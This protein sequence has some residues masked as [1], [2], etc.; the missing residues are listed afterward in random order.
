[1]TCREYSS[2]KQG[3]NY[4]WGALL[5]LSM[6]VLAPGTASAIT[7]RIAAGNSYSVGLKSDGTVWAWGYNGSGQLGD[8]TATS[9]AIPGKVAALADITTIAAG[10]SHVLALRGDGTVW[11]W[12]ANAVGQMGN[13][14]TADSSSPVQ[15]TGVGNVTAVAAGYGHSAV[16]KGD[17]TVWTWGDN[18]SG[19]LGNGSLI[20]RSRPV[21]VTGL[22]DVRGVAAGEWH[23]VVIKNDGTV[24]AWGDNSSGQLGNGTTIRQSTP[25]QVPGVSGIIAVAVGARHTIALKND[26]S[27]WAWGD[28]SSGQLG[29]GTALNRS[30]PVSIAGVPAG[31]MVSAN[32]NNSL[33]LGGNGTVWAWGDNSYGQ[34]GEGTPFSTPLPTQVNGVSGVTAVAAGTVHTVILKSDNTVWSWGYGKY[35]QLGY[36]P[37][38]VQVPGLNVITTVTGNDHILALPGDGTVWGW[39]DNN[40]GQLGDGTYNHRTTPAKVS[41][42][43]HVTKVATGG[44]HSA[45]IKDDGSLWT[46]G[47]NSFG[48]LGDGSTIGRAAPFQVSALSGAVA[49]AGGRGHTVAVK[50]D[51]TVW[52]W[53]A[54]ASGQLGDGTTFGRTLPV[55]VNGLSSVTAV[56]AG[57]SHTVALKRDGTVWSWGLNS[58]GQLGD[59]TTVNRPSPVQVLG[60]TGVIAVSA[61][62]SHTVV[63]K[64]DGTVWAWGA[65]V[66]GQL[67]DGSTVQRSAPVQVSGIVSPA[68]VVAGHNYTI[69]TMSDGS[70]LTWGANDL[71]QL[72]DGTVSSRS[73]PVL[74][75][76]PNRIMSVAGGGYAVRIDGSVWGWGYGAYRQLGLSQ[77][78]SRISLNAQTPTVTDFTLP[79]YSNLLSVPITSF[80]ALGDGVVTSYCV[81]SSN[82]ITDCIWNSVTPA[83]IM[84]P[85]DGNYTF[86]AWAR[87]AGGV[88]SLPVSALVTVDSTPPTVTS[89]TAPIRSNTLIIPSIEIIAT[90]LYKVTDYC[91]T[92]IPSSAGCLWSRSTPTTFTVPVQGS[93]TFYAWA[94]DLVGNVSLPAS[95][96]VVVDLNLP[97]L[98]TDVIP[99][100]ITL[101]GVLPMTDNFIV[102]IAPF[103]AT[104]ND[105]VNGYQVTLSSTAPAATDPNWTAAPPATVILPATTLSGTVQLYAW[106]RDW[107]GNI[108]TPGTAAMPVCTIDA[109]AGAGGSITGA[110]VSVISCGTNRL[111]HLEPKPGYRIASIS[112]DGSAVPVESD[113]LFS[114]VTTP[115]HTIVAT[116]ELDPFANWHKVAAGGNHTLAVRADGTL[117]AWGYNSKNQLGLSVGSSAFL[118]NP[119][120]VGISSLWEDVA[121][122]PTFSSGTHA[123]GSLWGWGDNSFGQLGNGTT[124]TLT[125]PTRINAGPWSAIDSGSLYGAGIGVNGT[126]MMWGMRPGTITPGTIAQ[127]G[128]DGNWLKLA[129][130]GGHTLAIK[131]DGTLWSWGD[132]VG[133]QLGVGT[134]TSL[135]LPTR[136]GAGASWVQI[137]AGK[138]HSVA[139]EKNGN[140]W[141]WGNNDSGQLGTDQLSSS[142]VPY[143]VGSGQIWTAIAAGDN[144][145]LA[146]RADGTLWAFGANL[147]GELGDGTGFTK[148]YFTQVGS[149]ADWKCISA[150]GSTSF[151][152][153]NDNS[154]WAWGANYVTP[155]LGGQLGDGTVIDKLSPVLVGTNT[156]S[157][158]I[159]AVAGFGGNISPS[160]PVTIGVGTSATFN[161]ASLVG[162][163]IAEV[164]VD[165]VSSLYPEYLQALT[166]SVRF[167][168]VVGPHR[169]EA[170]FAA[171][172]SPSTIT[173]LA[174][175]GGSISPSGTIVVQNGASQ[176]FVMGAKPGYNIVDLLVDDVSQGALTGYTFAGVVG[177]HTIR[178]V[179]GQVP[180]LP[181]GSVILNNGAP[182]TTS[183]GVVAAMTI[184]QA[185]WMRF[186]WDNTTWE[187]WLPYTTTRNV[188]LPAGDGVKTLYVQFRNESGNTSLSSSASILL[189]TTI[190]QFIVNLTVT[191]SG[192][193]TVNTDS[194]MSCDNGLCQAIVNV[195]TQVSLYPTPGPTSTFTGWSGDC[196]GT[197]TC[198]VVVLTDTSL[199]AT[200]SAAPK[201]LIGVTPYGTLQAAYGAA[202]VVGDVI[203]MMTG[204]D[205]GPLLADRSV[206]VTLSG[207]YNSEYT[208]QQGTTALPSPI[209]IR[210]GTV[211]LDR[212]IVK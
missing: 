167:D 31:G 68:D 155:G 98:L 94:R 62:D 88:V 203:R 129:A 69:A 30:T 54:N 33:L 22:T 159:T 179:T 188:I 149:A 105:L 156:N 55:R 163:R 64:S 16:V 87:D 186:S 125:N 44:F 157:Y 20:G 140:L 158:V 172:S 146:L 60:L 70:L 170:K 127:V 14:S 103:I 45:A 133:G 101:F 75:T 9:R 74:I 32:G 3:A 147:R 118:L 41:V 72:G 34:L 40:S 112:V 152:I 8:G 56:T 52:S 57:Y 204:S 176:V 191:G 117:W 100:T 174:D 99:P 207:G 130:G 4:L 67:G 208:A 211:V 189:A 59:G 48:Q 24:W 205:S 13:G 153:K 15:A 111:Y 89:F 121:A 73:I 97:L 1:M 28:N 143:Q 42:L 122:G 212:V 116:F 197:G 199:T 202:A 136:I 169:I 83:S 71:G 93:Y 11:S 104:D 51:G 80:A 46:W 141:A 166:T 65:N 180:T 177:N 78:Q 200:F 37:A 175:V 77:V 131:A 184:S 113:Y 2:A 178:L 194:G 35:G 19:Q 7:T 90:D 5:L 43:S 196:T 187:P 173:A 165:G 162:W 192:V 161:I 91:L 124:T 120:R 148:N 132:N 85:A 164:L 49:V 138:S 193:G 114:T 123:D 66:S 92:T 139:L 109:S 201:V 82:S 21:Q 38:P 168:N 107:A 185:T 110:G 119:I 6:M 137:A 39:G 209:L 58:S 190:Q 12:G 151:G 182:I 86:T 18:S 50:N 181:V 195:N 183:R 128:S 36:T 25:A 81:T 145:T 115:S 154:L 29:D 76:G 26:G 23:T 95:K 27:V 61:G 134:T 150:G 17:G 47:D 63:V 198:R 96:S 135:Y 144:H 206:T 171:I 102:P 108:S 210:A 160:G 84:V 79:A 10:D 126:L 106:A 142:T 53:G